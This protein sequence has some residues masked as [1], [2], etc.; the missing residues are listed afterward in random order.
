VSRKTKAVGVNVIV[1][2]GL[3]TQA[4]LTRCGSGTVD[5]RLI[6]E[7]R[8]DSDMGCA[9]QYMLIGHMTL[10]AVEM[11]WDSSAAGMSTS[12]V[13]T[14]KW[15]STENKRLIQD[16]SEGSLSVNLRQQTNIDENDF[17]MDMARHGNASTLM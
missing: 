1:V 10:P 5:Q 6:T 16:T 8:Q 7:M 15:M 17:I 11:C 12:A 3:Q 9:G 14:C 4:L 2:C 13:L